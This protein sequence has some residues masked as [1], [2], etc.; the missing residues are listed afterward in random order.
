MAE[1]VGLWICCCWE[2]RA[3]FGGHHQSFQ[4]FESFQIA[5][6]AKKMG[7]QR[8]AALA[9]NFGVQFKAAI[10]TFITIQMIASIHGNHSGHLRFIPGGRNH[11]QARSTA[12]RKS[13]MVAVEAIGAIL[14]VHREWD[15]IEGFEAGGTAEALR[16]ECLAQGT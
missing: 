9:L 2:S 4:G 5:I 3:V 16:M 8:V 10:L 15:A 1:E 11:F 6:F 12:W 14:L 13:L 7:F